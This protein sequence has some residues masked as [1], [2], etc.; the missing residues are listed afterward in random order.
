MGLEMKTSN[1]LTKLKTRTD[2]EAQLSG[3]K[4][5]KIGSWKFESDLD[6]LSGL[7]SSKVTTLKA[8]FLKR[9]GIQI[10]VGEER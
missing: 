7:S 1:F 9:I 6:D 8:S 4:K 3:S 5:S 2:Q 10:F